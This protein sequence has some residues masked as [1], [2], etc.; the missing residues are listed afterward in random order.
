MKRV[1]KFRAWDPEEQLMFLFGPYVTG[2][3]VS[4]EAF[5]DL[6]N[7]SE[8]EVVLMLWT[9]FTDSEGRDIYEGDVIRCN[10]ITWEVR[11][12]KDRGNWQ[13]YDITGSYASIWLSEMMSWG[14]HAKKNDSTWRQTILGNI[15]EN[16]ELIDG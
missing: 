3:T 9:G 8:R 7:I 4:L 2:S 11:W 13:A 6:N 10:G 12:M 14:T 16:P 15:Y 5:V 1:F